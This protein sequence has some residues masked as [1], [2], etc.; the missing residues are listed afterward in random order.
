MLE[1]REYNFHVKYVKGK[2][3]VV[4]DQL[5]RPVRFIKHQPSVAWLGLTKEEFIKEQCRDPIWNE[6]LNYLQGGVLP[7]RKIAK[8]SLDQ[9]E[10]LDGKLHYVRETKDA[11]LNY[12]VVVHR[13]LIKKALE[14]S[15]DQSGHFGQF[16]SIKQTEALFYWPSIKSDI[17]KYLRVPKLPKI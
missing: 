2:D 12:T 5:S 14:V 3:K 13:H 11:S 7:E 9:F 4:A 15:H 6:L 16:K 8:A 10:V 1:K 17:I